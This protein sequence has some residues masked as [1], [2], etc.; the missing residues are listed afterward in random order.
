MPKLLYLVI[1]AS[2]RN[3]AVLPCCTNFTI[4]E[5]GAIPVCHLQQNTTPLVSR[6]LKGPDLRCNPTSGSLQ[7]VAASPRTRRPHTR[8]SSGI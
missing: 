2:C 3:T 6:V 8:H 1:A 7:L 4:G 5:T